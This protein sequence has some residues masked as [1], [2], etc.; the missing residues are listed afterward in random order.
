MLMDRRGT[1][2]ESQVT[3]EQLTQLS[4]ML[5]PVI[6]KLLGEPVGDTM[7]KITCTPVEGEPAG[8][9]RMSFQIQVRGEDLSPEREALV[10]RLLSAGSAEKILGV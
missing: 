10:T 2:P 7:V 3:D 8:T 6:A 1:M 4:H 5:R 9:S